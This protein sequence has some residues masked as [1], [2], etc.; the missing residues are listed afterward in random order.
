M[1][2]VLVIGL[3]GANLD[4]IR[5]WAGEGVLPN[6]GRLLLAGTSGPLESTIPALSP[7]A[8][9]TLFT[10]KNPGKHGVYDFVRRRPGSYD[11]EY[12][13]NDLTKLGTIFHHLSIAGLRVAAINVPFTYPPEPVNGIMISGLGAP[14]NDRFAYPQD[15]VLQLKQ[16]GYT[17][18]NKVGF[19][20]K[21]PMDFLLY[22]REVT[23]TRGDV[24]VEIQRRESWDF[25]MAV[26]RDI[27]T[28]QSYYWHFMDETHPLHDAA[29]PE[30]LRRAIV[31]HY[32]Q[33]DSIVGRLLAN[34]DSTTS[35]FV[36][37]DHGGGALYREVYLNN[38]LRLRGYLRTND[39][40]P[41]GNRAKSVLRRLGITRRTVVR[42]LGWPRAEKLKHRF[43][44][45]GRW[46]PWAS[47][48]LA[49]RVDWQHT[50]AYALSHLGQIFLN[51]E[52]REPQGL[53]RNDEREQVLD[54][55]TAD[56]TELIDPDTGD[57]VVDAVY[58]REQVYHGPY[59]DF[60]PDL[61]LVLKGLSYCTHTGYE[62]GNDTI[63]AIPENH[64][65]GMHRMAGTLI[66]AG[67]GIVKHG[68][69]HGARVVDIA[70]TLLFAAG[71]PI[72]SD[73]DGEVQRAMFIS[74][75]EVSRS[76]VPES[77]V[78]GTSALLEEE[79]QSV[80]RHLQDLGYIE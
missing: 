39:K 38:W 46:L 56:L 41:V 15:L 18:N 55:L 76:L 34:I 53:V 74:P 65:T 77:T 3:D 30:P 68:T 51:E 49:E 36:V 60:A 63:F 27:D 75:K 62:F 45:A 70:P 29:P 57:K 67:P 37:S 72:P 22:L 58:R 9:T 73:M 23:A 25:F 44:D 50:T 35:V 43:P 32:Q 16:A 69:V 5:Q 80:R 59:V 64:E 1:N 20:A 2:K 24:I 10:G 42:A 7:P 14:D 26:F 47:P 54:R 13:R 21:R 61:N 19:D 28:V 48:S 33:V 79:E 6:F 8:W 71:V 66:A 11:L 78:H 31:D 52:G 12:V 4:L 40:L 17:V